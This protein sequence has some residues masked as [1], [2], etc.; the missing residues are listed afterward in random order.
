L[1]QSIRPIIDIGFKE[2]NMR[3]FTALLLSVLFFIGGAGSVL[4]CPWVQDVLKVKVL[5]KDCKCCDKC[6]KECPKCP[7]N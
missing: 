6:P 4:H 1:F 7:K 2:I 5:S 3:V